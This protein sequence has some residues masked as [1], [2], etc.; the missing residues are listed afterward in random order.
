MPYTDMQESVEHLLE[1]TADLE[2][3]NLK[4]VCVHGHA[5]PCP[6]VH[7][8]GLASDCCHDCLACTSLYNACAACLCCH[9]VPALNLLMSHSIDVVQ[10]RLLMWPSWKLKEQLKNR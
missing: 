8:M 9:Q 4:L 3:L 10:C 7:S 2:E 5:Q 6:M 1:D